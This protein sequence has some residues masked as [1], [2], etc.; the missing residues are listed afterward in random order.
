ML[1]SLMAMELFY[2]LNTMTICFFEKSTLHK[3]LPRTYCANQGIQH[4]DRDLPVDVKGTVDRSHN[5]NTFGVGGR[6][7]LSRVRS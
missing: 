1:L 6:T 7:Y 4:I 2:S 3:N 5:I